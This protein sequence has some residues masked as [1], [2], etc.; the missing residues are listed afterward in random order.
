VCLSYQEKGVDEQINQARGGKLAWI[1]VHP[2]GQLQ[3]PML[4]QINIEQSHLTRSFNWMHFTLNSSILGR[5]MIAEVAR[6]HGDNHR[7]VYE[8]QA[9]D[10]QHACHGREA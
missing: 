3:F 1:S 8:E 9:A 10:H 6:L 5:I 2:E 4:C 7:R